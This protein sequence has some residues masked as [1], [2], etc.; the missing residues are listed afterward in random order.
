MIGL[1]TSST[2]AL[3]TLAVV[4]ALLVGAVVALDNVEVQRQLRRY[5]WFRRFEQLG[6]SDLRYRGMISL[7][8]GLCGF[9]A[10]LT[11]RLL[12]PGT[13]VWPALAL[14]LL[15]VVAV[16]LGAALLERAAYLEG[17]R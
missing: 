12:F 3:L 9:A 8:L 2:G 11:L 15:T 16:T 1:L 4:F 5:S 17:Y 7:G 10:L 13:G 6:P 14:G